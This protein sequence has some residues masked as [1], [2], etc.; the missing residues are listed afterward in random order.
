[1]VFNSTAMGI[2]NAYTVLAG[3]V[4]ATKLTAQLAEV[5]PLSPSTNSFGLW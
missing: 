5:V 4:E 1:M 2:L 3:V